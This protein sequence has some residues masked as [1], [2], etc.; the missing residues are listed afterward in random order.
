VTV[1]AARAFETLPDD[2]SFQHLSGWLAPQLA[3]G[4]RDICGEIVGPEA[5][6]WEPVGTPSEYLA[7]NLAPPALSFLD[8][9]AMARAGG[10]RIEPGLVVGAGA[11][12]GAGARLEDVVVWDG[13]RVPARFE[14]R[15]GVYAGGRFVPCAEETQ[16]SER[17]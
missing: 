9:D 15:R 13:E 1:V 6:L 12:I 7:A 3:A 17:A 16:G 10:A 11:E 8:A 5:C 14:A 2:E 4:A